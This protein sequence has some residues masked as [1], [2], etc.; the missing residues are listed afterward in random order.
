[1]ST[2]KDFIDIESTYCAHNYNPI[3]VVIAKAERAHVWDAEG[4]KYLDMLSCYSALNQGHRHPRIVE[5]AIQQ[6]G[7]VTL[8]SRAFHNDKLGPFLRKLTD[9]T[10]MEMA[11]PMNTGAEAVE[12]GIKLARRWAYEKKKVP[13]D[14]AEVIVCANNFHGRTTTIIGF[15]TDENSRADFGPFTPGF[16]I[17]PYNDTK[18][19]ASAITPNTA[20]FLVEPIQGEAGVIVPSEGYLRNVREICTENNILL[21]L[22]EI[23]TGFC[24]TG[25]MF[26]FQYEAIKPDVLVVGKALGGGMMPISAVLSS[27]EVMSVLTPGSHGSTFGGNPL[28]CAI[29]AAALDVLIDEKLDQRSA[30]LGSY[31]MKRLKELKNP[32]FKEIRGR[33]L[34]IAVELQKE[35]GPA[36]KYT[37]AL[38][39]NGLLAKE[40]HETII[41]FAPPLV[42]EKHE[43]DTALE[44]IEKT[45]SAVFVSH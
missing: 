41:R 2:S 19:L 18:A 31:F 45:F 11:L 23:Q 24:R 40:T 9:L 26:C 3:P 36:R 38:M 17:I 20:A 43:I 1:M 15:S 33:G 42:I 8:T 22:D 6:L 28:A 37:E 44:I 25:K 35:A 29:G 34:L 5:A 7:R 16:K 10:G 32:L 27:K 21:I 14:E 13:G 30:E 4:K 12:T 39:R